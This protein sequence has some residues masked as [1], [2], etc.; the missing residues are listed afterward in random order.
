MEQIVQERQVHNFAEI[1]TELLSHIEKMGI[2]SSSILNE[3][4]GRYL[5]FIFKIDNQDFDFIGKK[6]GFNWSKID[7]FKD[8]RER[9]FRNSTPVGGT[10]LYIFNA[11][12]KA[13]SG[14]Y[15]AAIVY[16]SKMFVPTKD[17]VK[18]LKNQR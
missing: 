2:D 13:E 16:W 8:E 17:V 9:F 12:Q 3:Y 6:V 10:I 5:N 14:G 18:R 1:P 11:I 15:D 7:F 4:E